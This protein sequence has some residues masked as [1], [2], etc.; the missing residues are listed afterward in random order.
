MNGASPVIGNSQWSAHVS[1]K[2]DGSQAPVNSGAYYPFVP[3]NWTQYEIIWR[4]RTNTHAEGYES[5]FFLGE[6][7]NSNPDIS[8]GTAWGRHDPTTLKAGFGIGR[9][10]GV[11]RNMCR[12]GDT[13]DGMSDATDFSDV[14]LRQLSVDLDLRLDLDT[15]GGT[16]SWLATWYAK[17]PAD[18]SWT[19]VKPATKFLSE[20]VTMVGWSQDN[21]TT[22]SDMYTISVTEKA[23]A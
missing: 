8:G 22:V 11:Q 9:I 14:T 19:Q 20:D 6:G 5:I 7:L 16:N 15:R 23:T 12:R 10:F 18:S 13:T 1:Y 3:Q 4:T 21:F 17:N 2:A